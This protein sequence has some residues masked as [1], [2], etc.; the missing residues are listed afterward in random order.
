MLPFTRSQALRN[1]LRDAAAG[2]L[3]FCVDTV[4]ACE[5]QLEIYEFVG[6]VIVDKDFCLFEVG[7]G[8]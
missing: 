1:T 5:L 6:T 8:A 4:P 7:S 3:P 2:M